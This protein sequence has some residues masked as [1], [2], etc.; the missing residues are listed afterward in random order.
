MASGPQLFVG[1][2]VE[3]LGY[4]AADHFWACW[5]VGFRAP[6]V[7]DLFDDFGWQAQGHALTVYFGAA[8][9]LFLRHD[10]FPYLLYE[11]IKCITMCMDEDK[12]CNSRLRPNQNSPLY[13]KGTHNDYYRT[14]HARTGV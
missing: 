3:I 7:V 1:Q 11:F 4:D 13:E 12:S 10:H 8:H 5:D 2:A 6:E 9:W 14:Y